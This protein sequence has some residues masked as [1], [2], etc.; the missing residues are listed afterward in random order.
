M[1][2]R[3]CRSSTG[4]Q[5]QGM[6][7][8]EM[9]LV[10]ALIAMVGL[11]TAGMFSRGMAGMQLRSAGKEIANQL[12]ATRAEAIARGSVQRFLIEPRQRRWEAAAGRSGTWPEQVQV[13]FEGAAQLQP[14]AGQ[15]VI[16]F[17]P[18]GGG[19]GGRIV[20]RRGDARW[21]IN[22]GWLTGEVTSGPE[23]AR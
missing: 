6:S 22:V 13:D 2:R 16:E 12:R 18:D 15:G 3:S 7:L 10:I 19:S 14:A 17:H 9:L 8:L 20:L 21:R 1:P 11:V 4:A 23:R 5:A